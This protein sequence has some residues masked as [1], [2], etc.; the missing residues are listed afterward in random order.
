MS[1]WK[2]SEEDRAPGAAVDQGLRSVQGIRWLLVAGA[3]VVAV[4]VVRLVAAEWGGLGPCARFLT[5]TA[6]AL[7]IYAAGD[8]T[9]NRLRLP[10]AGSAFLFLFTAIV[11]LLGWGAAHLRLLETAFGWPSL[12]FGLGG[13]MVCAN[14][15][16]RGVLSCSDRLYSVALGA[17]LFAMPI[18][19]F[20]EAR[21]GGG[22]IFF[23]TIAG[24]FGLL[25]RGASRHVN[26]MLFHRDRA[27]GVD[28]PVHGLPFAMLTLVYLAGMSLLEGFAS[29]LA[30][31]LVF[32]ALALI[33]AGEEY[34][35]ALTRATGRKPESWPRRS[36]ALLAV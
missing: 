36:L 23:V 25:V 3:M 7:A 4:S 19:P 14:R 20:V 13:L 16:F 30:L 9:R 35:Q 31:P 8:V 2:S 6:G 12:A 29:H 27:R 28:L 32:V 33:D 1:T 22:E 17:L 18:L 15:V 34:Y 21:W 5:L 26:R 24:A 10:V 11:P